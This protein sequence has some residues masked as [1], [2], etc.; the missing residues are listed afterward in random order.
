MRTGHGAAFRIATYTMTSYQL[1]KIYTPTQA[2]LRQFVILAFVCGS[3]LLPAQAQLSNGGAADEG[4]PWHVIANGEVVQAN[5]A[6]APLDSVQVVARRALAQLQRAGYYQAQIDSVSVDSTQTPPA[7]LLYVRRGPRIHVGAIEIEGAQALSADALREVMTT[8]VGT[9]LDPDQLEDDVQALLDAYAAAGYPL[10]QIRIAEMQP[11]PGPAPSLQVRIRI[12]EGPALTFTRISVPD[13]VRS[14]PAYLARVTGLRPGAPMT[15][16]D[17]SAMQERLRETGLYQRVGEPALRITP[18]GGAIVHLPLEEEA[19]GTFD[20]AL[21]YLPPRGGNGSGQVV[22][23][24]QLQLRNLFGGGRVLGLQLDQRPGQV[25]TVDIHGTDPYVLG[26]PVQLGLRFVGEQRDSTYGKQAYH[27][28]GGYRFGEGLELVGTLVREVTKPGQAGT[29]LAAGRQRIDRARALFA[30][31]GVRFHQVDDPVNPRRG[32]W[33]ETNLERGRKVRSGQ[34]V[35]AEGDTTRQQNTQR[36]ERLRAEGR[37]FVPAFAQQVL[38]LGLDTRVLL[39]DTYDRSD[40]FRLGG[41]NSLRGYDED[42]FLGNVV[43][44]LLVEYRY[45]IDRVSYA[46]VF[47]DWGFVQTPETTNLDARRE[48]Y[49][50]FGIGLQ[51]GTELGRFNVSY[52]L[53]TEDPS[54]ANGRVHIG[55]SVGL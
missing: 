29:R 53:N 10:A 44:R 36:Q 32:F 37:L 54:P 46:Y 5:V 6:V 19:P 15:D 21:G 48:L 13:G 7:A 4:V 42:R 45:P 50:G 47:S 11:Q 51:F 2:V 9:A 49:P 20:L 25:S 24:G 27:M 38:A 16:Y 55:L 12:D 43:G 8:E 26:T 22:G 14:S 33:M 39:S 35:T 18:D 31:L 23:N 28:A 17:P 41:A 1:A 34:R 52:A 40:L 30:G 3:G